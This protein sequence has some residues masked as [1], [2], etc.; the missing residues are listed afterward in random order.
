MKC[1]HCGGE[2]RQRNRA[3]LITTGLA[4]CAAA[5]VLVFIVH[6]AVVILAAFVLAVTG[7]YFLKWALQMDGW[8]CPKC[9]RVLVERAAFNVL[10]NDLHHGACPGCGTRIPGV[11]L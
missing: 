11:D 2:L 6:L 10:K 9:G 7:A 1:T 8:W 5:L 4:L 3:R